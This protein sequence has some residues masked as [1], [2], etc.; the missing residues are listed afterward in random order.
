MTSAGI[1][2]FNRHSQA[3]FSNQNADFQPCHEGLY[4]LFASI[5]RTKPSEILENLCLTLLKRPATLDE[6][7]EGERWWYGLH[8]MPSLNPIPQIWLPHPPAHLINPDLDATDN[9]DHSI[10]RL[11]STSVYRSGGIGQIY[12]GAVRHVSDEASTFRT[13]LKTALRMQAEEEGLSTPELTPMQQYYRDKEKKGSKRKKIW[14]GRGEWEYEETKKEKKARLA[15]YKSTSTPWDADPG[16]DKSRRFF[17]QSSAPAAKG[18]GKDKGRGKPVEIVDDWALAEGEAKMMMV[19]MVCDH[20][21]SLQYT[22]AAASAPSQLPGAPLALQKTRK[23]DTTV[24]AD[25]LGLAATQGRH[26]SQSGHMSSPLQSSQPLRPSQS[27]QSSQRDRP[28]SSPIQSRSAM[29]TPSS[30]G[31][32]GRPRTSNPFAPKASFVPSS[33][34]TDPG[35]TQLSGPAGNPFKQSVQKTTLPMGVRPLV[36]S[37]TTR[38]QAPVAKR[39]PFGPSVKLGTPTQ[40]KAQVTLAPKT[41]KVFKV[42]PLFDQMKKKDPSKR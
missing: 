18:A 2:V 39:N 34:Q 32:P 1:E 3:Y 19:R 31:V 23:N 12:G 6:R 33:Q 22:A 17:T 26:A 36:Q 7:P 4:P 42:F 11:S 20:W 30:Q 38:M 13:N 41:V 10:G 35:S 14:T 25:I 15:S 24:L 9:Y 40:S 5:D 16:G 29:A 28:A 21:T 27:S 37:Q 8:L